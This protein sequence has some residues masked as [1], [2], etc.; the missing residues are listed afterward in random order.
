[1]M[2]AK[3]KKKTGSTKVRDK[4]Y[5]VSVKGKTIQ[6]LRLE[7]GLSQSQAANLV[8]WTAQR[9]SDLENDRHPDPRLSTLVSVCNALGCEI[10]DLLHAK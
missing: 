10:T 2:A 1:M 9:W 7:S 8:G 3:K 5:S 4:A 6:R